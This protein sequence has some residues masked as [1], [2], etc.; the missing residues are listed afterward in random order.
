M[1]SSDLSKVYT[2]VYSKTL[3]KETHFEQIRKQG[4]TEDTIKNLMFSYLSMTDEEFVNIFNMSSDKIALKDFV[5]TLTNTFK[6][7]TNKGKARRQQ[8]QLTIG[9]G[10]KRKSLDFDKDLSNGLKNKLQLIEGEITAG[11]NNYQLLTE[12][13]QVLEKMVNIKIGRAH[14]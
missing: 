7:T 8:G 13:K 2:A 9:Y 11:N 14:V 5:Y 1:C 10:I 6:L 3:N 4:N 12:L